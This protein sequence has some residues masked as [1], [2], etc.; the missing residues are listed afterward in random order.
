MDAVKGDR[1]PV[2]LRPATWNDRDLLLRWSND[3]TV[4][5]NSRD[6]R[7]IAPPDHE[8]WLRARLADPETRI[9]IGL[10]DGAP[11]GVVRIEP[12]GDGRAEVSISLDATYRGLHLATPL[13]VVARER[14]R[15]ERGNGPLVAYVR[16]ENLVSLRAFRAAGYRDRATL[17][18]LVELTLD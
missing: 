12:R 3:P 14:Y 4:R 2:T 18:D 10:R 1:P 15:S 8:N 11:C 13:L 7:P 17:G 16:P 5:L 9:Y 6:P